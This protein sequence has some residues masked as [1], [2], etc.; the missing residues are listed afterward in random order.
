MCWAKRGKV[1]GTRHAL[2]LAGEPHSSSC[3]QSKQAERW[4]PHAARRLVA[5]SC[6]SHLQ[7]APLCRHVIVLRRRLPALRSRLL[8]ALRLPWKAR[9]PGI[10]MG[11][12]AGS[13]PGGSGMPPHAWQHPCLQQQHRRSIQGSLP[14]QAGQQAPRDVPGPGAAAS[15]APRAA[16][17]VAVG[18]PAWQS[19]PC[20]L[21]VRGV[22]RADSS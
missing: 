5:P 8:L 13:H 22:G 21:A 19:G 18:L 14:C 12:S 2:S 10:A 16:G 4:A 1:G 20:R 7:H 11:A 15:D 9:I 6:S 3:Q 17:D